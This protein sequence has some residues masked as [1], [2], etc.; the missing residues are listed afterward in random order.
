[1][2]L[3]SVL[4]VLFLASCTH[5]IPT[6]QTPGYAIPVQ[7]HPDVHLAQSVILDM[8][9]QQ[10]QSWIQQKAIHGLSGYSDTEL[11]AIARSKLIVVVG[12]GLGSVGSVVIITWEEI[13][14]ELAFFLTWTVRYG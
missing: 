1:M 12:G 13:P 11:M 3:I 6:L 4:S 5:P 2:R 14:T 10:V 7:I 9:D 8:I